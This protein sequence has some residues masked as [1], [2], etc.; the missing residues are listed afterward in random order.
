MS[1]VTTA[2]DLEQ[3]VGEINQAS[4]DDTNEMDPYDVAALSAYLARQDNLFVVCHEIRHNARTLLGIASARF[5]LKPYANE[6]WLYVDEVDVC[7]DQRR[8]GAGK[9][10][11]QKLID[12]ARADGCEEVWLGADKDNQAANALYRSLDPDDVSHVMGYTYETAA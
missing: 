2:S 12:M 11:M 5:Q 7:A 4:W 3:L 1:V 9:A 10:M 8:K 6:R